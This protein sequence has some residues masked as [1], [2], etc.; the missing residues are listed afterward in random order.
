MS[1]VLTL[2][3]VRKCFYLVLQLTP[4]TK[5]ARLRAHSP[6]ALIRAYQAVKEKGLPVY[7][8]AREYA[9]QMATL[10]D[11]VDNRVSIGCTKSGPEILLSQLE[12]AKLVAHIK[13][14]AAVGYGYTRAEV[15]SMASDYAVHLGKRRED[16]KNLSMQWFY[17]FIAL[18]RI[19]CSKAI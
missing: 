8:T 4:A 5:R 12:E 1:W 14:L 17:S 16:Q 3:S 19:A 11:R 7:R 6:T 10:R 13:D 18:V 9:V 15:I 2:Q